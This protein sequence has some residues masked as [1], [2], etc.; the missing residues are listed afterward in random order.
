MESTLHLVLRLR[1]G[2]QIFVKTLTG[3]T[4]TLKR[5]GALR[6]RVGK[7]WLVGFWFLVFGF[8]FLVFWFFFFFPLT[9][10]LRNLQQNGMRKNLRSESADTLNWAPKV[11]HH[12]KYHLSI[13]L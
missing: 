13:M 11:S 6:L 12:S 7:G 2:M 10:F 1:G 4:I 3:K 9:F 8:S 5:S